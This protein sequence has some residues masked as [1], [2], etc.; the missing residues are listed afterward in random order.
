MFD[1][2][3]NLF[4][5]IRNGQKNGILTI[6]YRHTHTT[7]AILNV[8]V[9]HGYVRGYR[10]CSNP[11]T[12]PIG[13]ETPCPPG[14]DSALEELLQGGQGRRKQIE[15]LLKYRNKKAAINKLVRIS[16]PSQRIYL[17]SDQLVGI[18]VANL[19]KARG[20]RRNKRNAASIG[21]ATP[22]RTGEDTFLFMRGTFILSTS[23]G[24]MSSITAQ[25]LHVGGEVI[26][27]V[28]S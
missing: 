21:G 9:D 15:I 7:I 26:G 12:T 10:F 23:K 22:L 25:K 8:L 18:R 27:H 14:Y 4:S 5:H 1:T 20:N 19:S 3:S 6:R 11:H 28:C 17:S 16:K 24:I 13:K 2:L